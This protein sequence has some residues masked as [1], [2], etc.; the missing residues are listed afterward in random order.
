LIKAKER[1]V[2]VRVI[3]DATNPLGSGSKIGKLREA[4]VAVKTEN[5]AGKMH[6]K[7]VIIDD[8]YVVIGSM[9]FSNSGEGRNAENVVILE[10]A[11]VAQFYRGY[12]EYLW[13]KI[14]ER[15]LRMNPR[16]EGKWSI[17][18]CEDGIDNNF[19]GKIDAA[20]VGCQ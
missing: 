14:P 5:Y 13:A 17:G 3:I 20:D 11:G 1:G 18:S 7:S 9:N 16:A 8:K 4:G 10:D 12:F 2:D 15:Y 19:D 6:S